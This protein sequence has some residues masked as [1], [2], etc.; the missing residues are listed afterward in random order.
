MKV[1]SFV[2]NVFVKLHHV[3]RIPLK[4]LVLRFLDI[5][6]RKC[7][8]GALISLSDEFELTS[9]TFELVELNNYILECRLNNNFNSSQELEHGEYRIRGVKRYLGEF[10]KF[11]FDS[12]LCPAERDLNWLYELTYLSVF[13]K[14]EPYTA[15][16]CTEIISFLN[17]IEAEQHRNYSSS[18]LAWSVISVANRLINIYAISFNLSKYSNSP[19]VLKRVIRHGNIC[20][21]YLDEFT[22]YYLHYNHVLFGLAAQLVWDFSGEKK[23]IKNNCDNYCKYLEEQLNSDGFHAE[24]SPTY[25]LHVAFL[26]HCIITGVSFNVRRLVGHYK[27]MKVA[28]ET[29]LH[30]DGEIAIFGDSAIH[31]APRPEVVFSGPLDSRNYSSLP[32]SGYYKQQSDYLA[33]IFDAGALGP[34]DNPGHGHIDFLSIEVSWLGSR[35]IVDPGVASY[36]SGHLREQTRS[37]STHNGPKPI[38]NTLAE[39]SGAFQVGRMSECRLVYQEHR[40]CQNILVGEISVFGSKSIKIRRLV[41]LE[42]SRLIV[43]DLCMGSEL[44]ETRF[45]VSNHYAPSALIAKDKRAPLVSGLLGTNI[46]ESASSYYPYGPGTEHL[47]VAYLVRSFNLGEDSCAIIAMHNE[48]EIIE[49]SLINSLLVKIRCSNV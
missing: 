37:A 4:R 8:R 9:R 12:L 30:P 6:R 46:S 28:I 10:K 26:T 3:S 39:L 38:T 22:E 13:L 36:K 44:A 27:A 14:K 47:S 34:L 1:T 41:C 23:D 16:E 15:T 31:D 32:V 29:L 24:L 43:I 7:K 25:H 48:N 17:G 42:D 45:I 40:G 35:F 18:S 11:D 2:S 21:T 20:R 19:E 5:L 49:D 33:V